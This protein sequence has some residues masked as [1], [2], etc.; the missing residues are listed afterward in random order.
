V[1]AAARPA[2]GAEP[3]ETLVLSAERGRLTLETREAVVVRLRRRWARRVPSV[4]QLLAGR[5]EESA[6]EQARTA[7]RLVS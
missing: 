2:L 7:G 4:D 1:P 6:R 5:R 3:G